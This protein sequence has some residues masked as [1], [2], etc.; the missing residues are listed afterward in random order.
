MQKYERSARRREAT[1]TLAYVW[2]TSG[3]DW[4][5]LREVLPEMAEACEVDTSGK[6]KTDIALECLE[7][8]LNKGVIVPDSY[9]APWHRHSNFQNQTIE[10]PRKLY[11]LEVRIRTFYDSWLWK[12]LSYQV[13]KERGNR[14]ECCGAS[15]NM[16]G[17]RIVADH[18]KSVRK[19]WHLRLDPKNIQV[20]CHDC[21]MGKG[22]RDE[23]DWRK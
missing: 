20:L 7:Q 2:E 18:I 5:S 19:H 9:V 22:A 21:N 1:R 6:S 16:S 12:K 11:Q 17:V 13:R 3:F 8:V 15:S 14:C 10:K 4:T 23:T